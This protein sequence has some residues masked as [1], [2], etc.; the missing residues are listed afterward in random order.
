MTRTAD[1]ASAASSAV[2]RL[3]LWLIVAAAVQWA[4]LGPMARVAFAE[5]V[6]ALTVAFWRATLGA[7][8]FAA[9]ASFTQAPPL[10]R[11]DRWPAALLGVAGMA[12]MYVT[13][14]KSVQYGGAALAAILLYAAPVWVALGA[15]F[16]LRERVSVSEA[17]AL[18]LTLFGVVL[19]AVS[20]RGA[21]TE[22]GQF[23]VTWPV[24]LFGTLSGLSYAGYFLMGRP[25]FGRNAPSRV[26]AW[27]LA[28]ASVVLLP[29]VEWRLHSTTAWLAIGFLAVVCTFGAY[30]SNAT[31][32]RTVAASRAATVATLEPVLA[33]VAAWLVWGERLAPLGLVGALL[34]VAGIVMSARRGAEVPQRD[35]TQ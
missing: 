23:A 17:G 20:G 19:V 35:V 4:M 8:L 16:L 2:S 31:G 33:V 27:A 5:G 7:L 18:A 22:A 25:L 6:S 29:F 12:V 11:R 14:F 9:H 21:S 34:V 13:Y 15:H 10:H 24:L 32:L 3:G 30:L 26:L 1:G 28:A